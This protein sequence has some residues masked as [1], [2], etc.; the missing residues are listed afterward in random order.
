MNVTEPR[1][2]TGTFEIKDKR[3]LRELLYKT[4]TVRGSLDEIVKILFVNA[5]LNRVIVHLDIKQN[6]T[7]KKR[8]IN[9]KWANRYGYTC[10]AY[11]VEVE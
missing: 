3:A 6:R 8:R 10:R 1:E 4:I 9:K 11:Y 7:H 5:P 2:I